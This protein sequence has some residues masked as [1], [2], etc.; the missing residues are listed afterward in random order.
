MDFM[1]RDV[2]AVGPDTS[3]ETAARM[4]A[5]RRISG[6]PVIDNGRVVG[7]VS[8]SDLVDPDADV[9]G[10]PGYP[11]YYR[12]MDGLAE[13]IGDDVRVRPGRVSEVMT[14]SVVSIAGDATIVEAANR[15]LQL[16]VHRLLVLRGDGELAGVVTTVDLLRAFVHAA[17]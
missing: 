7:V 1:T 14:T 9:S 17:A 13:E 6:A 16:G 2:F 12:V 11:L 5:Q 8:A 3:L 4:L 15:M 10:I